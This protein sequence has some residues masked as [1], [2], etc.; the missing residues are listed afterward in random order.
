[1]NNDDSKYND[2]QGEFD[3]YNSL[4]PHGNPRGDYET[5]PTGDKGQSSNE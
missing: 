4:G 2:S 1:M 3:Y 5:G